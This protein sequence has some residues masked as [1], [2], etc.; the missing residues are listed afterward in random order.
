MESKSTKQIQIHQIPAGILL[1]DT[2]TEIF[3]CKDSKKT[4]FVTNGQTHNFN[5]LKGSM[6]AQI[7]AE[8]LNDDVAMEDLKNLPQDE[9]IE[10]FAFCNYGAADH[11]PDFCENGQLKKS[12][13]FLC[14]SNC[15]CLKW[16]SKKITVDGKPL[17][18]REIEI[19]TM[20][21]S[22]LADKQIADELGISES[23][24]NTHKH[25][26]FEKASVQSKAG[27]ITK[28]VQQKIIQ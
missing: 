3:G 27:L 24:L 6:K 16:K 7:F 11:D 28:A 23:T 13:N 4:Y 14:S 26:L 19:V 20:M 10:K 12:D 21:A 15:M 18:R 9:A 1:G 22:D 25:H 2:R 17:T 8:L 5:Q